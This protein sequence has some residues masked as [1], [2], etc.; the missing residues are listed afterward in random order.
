MTS[1]LL[2]LRWYAHEN[3]LIGSWCV[4]AQDAPPARTDQVIAGFIDE[5]TARYIA[6]LHNWVRFGDP[7]PVPA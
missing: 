7:Q 6:E 3:D 4:T 2:D 1:D 5:R